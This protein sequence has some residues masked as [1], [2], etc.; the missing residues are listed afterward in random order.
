MSQQEST[1]A[2]PS[3]PQAAQANAVP[4]FR[5]LA[6]EVRTADEMETHDLSGYSK[7][8]VSAADDLTDKQLSN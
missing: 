7:A 8:Q 2:A 5:G 6:Y 4:E 3:R 1:Y